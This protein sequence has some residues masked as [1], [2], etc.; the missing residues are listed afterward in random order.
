MVKIKIVCPGESIKLMEIIGA[1]ISEKKEEGKNAQLFIIL[2]ALS[3]L[4]A[5]SLK[6]L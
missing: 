5:I 6:V 4:D 1:K 2:S 3:R